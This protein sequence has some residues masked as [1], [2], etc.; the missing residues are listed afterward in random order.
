[1]RRRGERI[2][3]VMKYFVFAVAAGWLAGCATG[4]R[5][6]SSREQAAGQVKVLT[7]R[8]DGVSFYR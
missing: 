8:R 2:P 1:M 6:M 5:P 4:E 7:S 3:S